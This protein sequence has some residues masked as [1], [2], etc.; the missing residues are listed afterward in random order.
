MDGIANDE[1]KER[2]EQK[3]EGAG[4]WGERING[5]LNVCVCNENW[6]RY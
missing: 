3:E 5:Y 2:E 6:I 4:I 1:R